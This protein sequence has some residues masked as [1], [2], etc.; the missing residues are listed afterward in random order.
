MPVPESMPQSLRHLTKWDWIQ[1][2]ELTWLCHIFPQLQQLKTIHS[3]LDIPHSPYR[4]VWGNERY[5]IVEAYS[6]QFFLGV[7]LIEAVELVFGHENEHVAA[8]FA[9]LNKKKSGVDASA[10]NEASAVNDG[11]AVDNASTVNNASAINNAFAVDNA[12]AVNKASLTKAAEAG[13]D[14]TEVAADDNGSDWETDSCVSSDSFSSPSP[15]LAPEP[16]VFDPSTHFSCVDEHVAYL[17]NNIATN[18]A[19]LRDLYLRNL[20]SGLDALP[21]YQ[22]RSE[23]VLKAALVGALRIFSRLEHFI[24]RVFRHG[25]WNGEWLWSQVYLAAEACDADHV[26]DEGGRARALAE[27]TLG[28][29]LL[30]CCP[31]DPLHSSGRS[32]VEVVVGWIDALIEHQ[33]RMEL[34]REASG[35][36]EE[37]N[38]DAET[39]VEAGGS[40]ENDASGGDGV[41]SEAETEVEEGGGE[42]GDQMY[43]SDEG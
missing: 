38:S 30:L 9:E 34:E 2:A 22:W 27:S 33:I 1:F 7:G 5:S 12:A 37:V 42:D 25:R 19:P 17:W 8:L 32:W 24:W 4:F 36:G 16:F 31:W 14:N 39:E 10:A 28:R 29:V 3:G 35:D 23:D 26:V 18:A 11:S 13:D 6:D 41:S 21:L 20:P 40:T 43:R 15:K